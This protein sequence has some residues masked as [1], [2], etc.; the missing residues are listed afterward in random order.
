MHAAEVDAEIHCTADRSR[1]GAGERPNADR[2]IVVDARPLTGRGA[3]FTQRRIRVGA[4]SVLPI[5]PHRPEHPGRILSGGAGSRAG[6]VG[7]Q[8]TPLRLIAWSE[9]G[10]LL[11]YFKSAWGGGHASDT[12]RSPA[13]R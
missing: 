2:L 6:G 12:G 4:R 11:L 3:V 10:D 1:Q 5:K 9:H 13:R 7:A 8:Q